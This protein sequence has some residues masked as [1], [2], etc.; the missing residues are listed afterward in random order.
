MKLNAGVWRY[1][2]VKKKFELYA[3]GGSNQWGADWDDRGQMFFAACVIPHMWQA[4]QGGRYQRQG[5][6]H[7]NRHTYADLQ[8]IADFGA[9]STGRMG[10]WW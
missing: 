3:E 7:G 6:Q 2:P 1:H 4:I 5:G 8:T 10:T 9:R